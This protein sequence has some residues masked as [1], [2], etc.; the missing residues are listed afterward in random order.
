LAGR[1][2][3]ISIH[4]CLL[5]A[6]NHVAAQERAGYV[7]YAF[8]KEISKGEWICGCFVDHPLSALHITWAI[9]P[10]H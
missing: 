2:P 7:N 5:R 6:S 8:L 9:E 10:V 3:K 1:C 4:S